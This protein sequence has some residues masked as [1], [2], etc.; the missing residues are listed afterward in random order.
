MAAVN[1][2]AVASAAAARAVDSLQHAVNFTVKC[3]VKVGTYAVISHGHAAGLLC[4]FGN[5]KQFLC[6]CV[7]LGRGSK[8]NSFISILDMQRKGV[9]LSENHDGLDP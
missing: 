7:L 2:T 6:I 9:W 3:S 8:T 4:R 1:S 5:F